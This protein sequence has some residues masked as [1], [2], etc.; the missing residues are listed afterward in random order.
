MT[1]E[2]ELNL[3]ALPNSVKEKSPGPTPTG[4]VSERTGCSGSERPR[5]EVVIPIACANRATREVMAKDVGIL[6]WSVGRSLLIRVG[7][8]R[9]FTFLSSLTLSREVAQGVARGH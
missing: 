2:F 1:H 4:C 8:A 7:S 5:V 3:S 6:D 9:V